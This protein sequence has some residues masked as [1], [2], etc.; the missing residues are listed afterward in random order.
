MN[1][2]SNVIMTM[3]M[4]ASPASAP[5]TPA[6]DIIWSDGVR[7]ISFRDIQDRNFATL[8]GRLVSF[9]E[10]LK[11]N[12][13]R[14]ERE[15]Y[16]QRQSTRR[17]MRLGLSIQRWCKTLSATLRVD[18]RARALAAT[19]AGAAVWLICAPFIAH[20]LQ[21]AGNDLWLPNAAESS[22]VVLPLLLL[23]ST[24]VLPRFRNKRPLR[25]LLSGRWEIEAWKSSIAE[26][27]VSLCHAAVAFSFS[28]QLY[29]E[30]DGC[31]AL[32]GSGA[33]HYGCGLLRI[34]NIKARIRVS[35]RRAELWSNRFNE[36]TGRLAA[37]EHGPLRFILEQKVQDDLQ[38]SSPEQTDDNSLWLGS[39]P[40]HLTPLKPGF[41]VVPRARST[42]TMG[43]FVL[44]SSQFSGNEGDNDSTPAERGLESECNSLSDVRI[45]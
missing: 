42:S 17:G 30:E 27:D 43:D 31:L 6:W 8:D 18:N 12:Y 44:F 37:Y 1:A 35:P 32:L 39:G 34:S 40:H 23:L 19:V 24:L 9:L 36:Q 10:D 33:M 11:R 2:I 15:G 45:H 16:D 22:T 20:R 26:N 28:S 14:S 25:S 13:W 38:D 3:I 7:A 21:L 4:P 29:S 41:Y 5:A